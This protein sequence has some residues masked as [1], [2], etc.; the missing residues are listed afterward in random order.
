MLTITTSFYLA[1]IFPASKH[2]VLTS[3]ST[4]KIATDGVLNRDDLYEVYEHA[5]ISL[6]RG[7]YNADKRWRQSSGKELHLLSLEELADE[8]DKIVT[9]H[10]YN[11]SN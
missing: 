4:Y 7:L 3:Q 5:M 1:D 11:L 6:F 8:L 2:E 9:F 10:N